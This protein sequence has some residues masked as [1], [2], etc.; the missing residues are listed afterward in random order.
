MLDKKIIK[1][2]ISVLHFLLLATSKLLIGIGIGLVI[3]THYWF[4]QPLWFLMIIT[5]GAI[6]I[7][8]L[9]HLTKAEVREEVKL[10]GK[11]KK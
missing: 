1:K 6:L 3:A 5:G 10:T 8:T 2:E 9:Y 7:P 11:L 4:I